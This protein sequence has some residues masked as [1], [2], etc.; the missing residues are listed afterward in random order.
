[1]SSNLAIAEL[2][3][4]LK[5]NP[6]DNI[7]ITLDYDKMIEIFLTIMYTTRI[8]MKHIISTK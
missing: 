1:M 5:N 2:I 8:L 4:K 3:W 7:S 6:T